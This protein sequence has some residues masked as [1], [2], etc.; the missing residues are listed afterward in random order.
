MLTNFVEN[1]WLKCEEYFPLN[2]NAGPEEHGGYTITNLRTEKENEFQMCKLQITDNASQVTR[3]V[4]HYWYTGWPDH[5]VPD[6][7][8]VLPRCHVGAAMRRSP[9]AGRVSSTSAAQTLDLTALP[10]R[11]AAC[12]GAL[13]PPTR[14]SRL[15]QDRPV[16][17]LYGPRAACG[18][19]RAHCGALLGGGGAHGLLHGKCGVLHAARWLRPGA[20]RPLHWLRRGCGPGV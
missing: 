11:G 6:E 19:G 14:P 16:C 1:N 13:L 15:G 8:N 3:E 18:D 2:A 10:H 5:G 20:P 7:G 12:S 4:Q 9:N 17:R